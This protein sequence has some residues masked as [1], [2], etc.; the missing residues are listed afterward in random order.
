MERL[1]NACLAMVNN[2]NLKNLK[3]N[4]VQILYYPGV[5]LETYPGRLTAVITAKG[6]CNMY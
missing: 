2:Q 6:Y 5:V 1:E 4:N 3:N